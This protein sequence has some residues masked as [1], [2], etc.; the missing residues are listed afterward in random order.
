KEST[1]KLLT[2]AMIPVAEGETISDVK[3]LDEVIKAIKYPIVI[4]PLNG[5]H[6]KGATVNITNYLCAVRAFERAQEFSKQVIVEKD[7]R[8]YDYRILVIN[9]KFIAA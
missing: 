1:K 2:A 5:N 8:G 9:Y 3:N 4:K 6:G 7:I